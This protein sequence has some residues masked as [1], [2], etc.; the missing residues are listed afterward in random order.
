MIETDSYPGDRIISVQHMMV[1]DA[2]APC[3]ARASAS[4]ILIMEN[5]QILVLHEEGIQLP[6]SYQYRGMIWIVDIFF[7]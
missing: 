5:R 6:V 1:A 3:T 4:V 7:Y 2:V